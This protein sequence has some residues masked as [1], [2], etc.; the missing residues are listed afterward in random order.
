MQNLDYQKNV[1]FGLIDSIKEE[2][3]MISLEKFVRELLEYSNPALK[4]VKTIK[5]KF[6]V[7]AFVEEQNFSMQNIRNMRGALADEDSFDDLLNDLSK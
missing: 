4:Y 5:E 6:D 1:V 7:D 2:Q 3:L